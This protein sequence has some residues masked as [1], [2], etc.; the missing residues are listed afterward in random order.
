VLGL[1]LICGVLAVAAL[2][3]WF[4]AWRDRLRFPVPGR[5][6]N[7]LHLW[8]TG[9]GAPSVI[10]ES[11]IAGTSLSWK[12]VQDRVSSFARV[13]S[14]DRASLGWS[15]STGAP[16]T[17]ENI[18]RELRQL[19][20]VAEIPAPYLL[21]GHSFGG[22][23]VRHFAALHPEEVAGIVLVD[24]VPVSDWCPLTE[25]QRLRLARGVKLSRRGAWLA[26]FGV[27]RLALSMLMTGSPRIPKLLARLSAGKGAGVTDSLTRE[28]RKLPREVWPM[29]AAQWCL[30]KSFRGMAD[31]LEALPANAAAA[32]SPEHIPAVII[33]ALHGTP[34]QI[35]GAIHYTAFQTGH[36]IQLDEPELVVRAIQDVIELA[37]M[38]QLEQSPPP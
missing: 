37:C 18:V 23:V 10:L 30:P 24:A 14:Y 7:G 28:V 26:R 38:P 31:Y 12:P 25:S 8:A 3:Q 32:R 6:V 29:V 22:L 13:C 19:L 33:T 15:E 21:V 4:G 5:V 16:R 9:H 36:W 11:G 27:V 35:P 1:F 34:E 20:R 17:V 2:Y